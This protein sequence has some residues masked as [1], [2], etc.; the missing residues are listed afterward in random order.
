C[1]LFPS[2]LEHMAGEPAFEGGFN[3]AR[4]APASAAGVLGMAHDLQKSAPRDSRG[5]PGACAL[6]SVCLDAT[7]GAPMASAGRFAPQAH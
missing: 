7:C 4:L 3:P 5:A 1:G 6:A 2:D